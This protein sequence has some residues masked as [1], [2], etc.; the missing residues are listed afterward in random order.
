METNLQFKEFVD[1]N[2][3]KNG[4][5]DVRVISVTTDTRRLTSGFKTPRSYRYNF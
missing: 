4:L 3:Q 2:V 1:E 5:C